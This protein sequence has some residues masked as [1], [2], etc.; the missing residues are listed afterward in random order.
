[1]TE[2]QRLLEADVLTVGMAADEA[3]RAS[4]GTN[5]V[6]YLR[7]HVA[8]GADLAS[9]GSI[10]DAA[11]EVRLYDTPQSLDE[12]IVQI[13]A[14]RRAAGS[15]RLTAYSMA[16]IESRGWG[17]L[18]D[19]LRRLVAA[20]LQDVAELPVD[21]VENLSAS[22]RA[23]EGAGANPQR[24]TVAHPLGE[25]RMAIIAEVQK[26][27]AE[28]PRVRRFSPL[29]R[30]APIDKPT[31]GYDDVRMVALSRLALA[32][33]SIEVDWTLY[34]PKLAQVALTFGADHLDA[35]SASND[36][37]LGPRRTTIEDVERNIR[38]AGFEPEEYRPIA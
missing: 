18:P 36:T 15:R 28:H 21:R 33:A 11:T 31:T 22:I 32:G 26:T 14:L 4:T 16:E 27:M 12:A 25:R 8:T 13:E 37:T 3:R 19:V 2:L 6:T 10:P 34:G 38:A 20:G 35:V 29:P 23:L 1:M 7:V 30:V 24:I 9:T 5:V 17:Q